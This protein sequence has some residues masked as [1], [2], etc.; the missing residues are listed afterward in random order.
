MRTVSRDARIALFDLLRHMRSRTGAR[1]AEAS[2][3]CGGKKKD[4]ENENMLTF[5]ETE[6]YISVFNLNA[7]L[8]L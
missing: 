8:S 1:G 3:S 2:R 6:A 4:E 5:D 7:V